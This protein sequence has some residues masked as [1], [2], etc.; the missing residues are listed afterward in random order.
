MS[1]DPRRDLQVLRQVME[2]LS[3]EHTLEYALQ[4]ITDAALVLLP[5]DHA[6]VR[7]LDASGTRLLAA[8]RSGAGIDQPSLDMARG[9][10]VA[11]WV[12][13]HAAAALVRDARQDPRF[14]AAAGQG[15]VVRSIVAA[16]LLSG[17]KAIGVLSVSSAEPNAFSDEDEQLARI[18]ANCS[19]PRLEKDRL[20]RLAIADELTLAFSANYLTLRMRQEMDRARHSA[21]PLSVVVMDLDQL[22]R[23]NKAFG[24]ALGDAVLSLFAARVRALLRRYDAFVRWGGDEFVVLL[25]NTSPAQAL[26]TAERLRALMAEEPMEPQPGGLLT[27]TVSVGVATWNGREE[28][29][30]LLDRAAMAVQEVKTAGG[31]GVARAVVP[32]DEAG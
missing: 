8:A 10:G 21:A 30:A 7:L 14:L 32:A 5:G 4:E 17:G 2:S 19:V 29:G 18:L 13:E 20:E 26:A 15:F 11:G 24:R 31:N 1:S 28:S 9:E 6:S 22:D 25:P 12:V 3:S 23:I 27:Q 16:P